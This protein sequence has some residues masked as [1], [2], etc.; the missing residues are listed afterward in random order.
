MPRLRHPQPAGAWILFAVLSCEALSRPPAGAAPLAP[1]TAWTARG[2]VVCGAAN[3]QDAPALAADGSGG[4]FL[5]WED[6][7]ARP[8]T[9]HVYAQHLLPDGTPA[10]GWAADGM[11]VCRARGIQ[12]APQVVGD[13][14]GGLFAVWQDDRA[15]GTL[16]VYGQ[17]LDAT[18]AVVSGWNTDGNALCTA[19]GVQRAPGLVSDGAGGAIV[20][21]EDYRRT[22]SL[23]VAQRVLG[24]GGFAPSW[25]DTGRLLAPASGGQVGPVM[26]TDGA[27]GAIVAWSDGRGGFATSPDIYAQRIQGDGTI[28]AG[29]PF[30]G[31]PVCAA[32]GVQQQPAIISDAAGGAFLAWTDSRNGPLNTFAQ[33]VS[34][35][36]TLPAGWVPDGISVCV[37]AFGELNP[38]LATDGAGRVIVT[39]SDLRGGPANADIYAQRLAPDGSA[40]WLA[41]GVPVSVA[42]GDQLTPQLV[43]DGAGGAIV[44]WQDGRFG[45]QT[46][47][48]AE[49]VTATGALSLG[50]PADGRALADTNLVLGPPQMVTDGAGGVILGWNGINLALASGTPDIFAA[51]LLG[52]GVVPVL[53]S[54]V[55]ADAWPD[56]VRLRWWT[57]RASTAVEIERRDPVSAW[58]SR[59]TPVTDGTGMLEW[60]DRDVV[61]GARYGW[62][63]R[64]DGG[65]AG[66]IWATVPLR[67]LAIAGIAPQPALSEA[68]VAVTLDGSAPARLSLFDLAGRRRWERVLDGSDP[69]PRFVLATAALEPGVYLLRLTQSGRTAHARLVVAR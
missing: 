10:P 48:Y 24:G 34:G 39:W 7:R 31:L 66:E 2:L 17:H 6:A 13:G 44:A 42:P 1:D 61:P 47:L 56:R 59:A 63:L 16:R 8:D 14:S 27:G 58:Q 69:A 28:P 51:R 5:V 57:P 40:E 38:Q 67:A 45:T 19:P 36:G 55:S 43:Y 32:G 52:S 18:G 62:R 23:V 9:T 54:A 65:P 3:A 64:V 68:R 37:T 22:Q 49:R 60:E 25:P 4:V 53:A 12:T 41:D 21:W 35:A 33:H 26:A 30:S 29:W 11:P 50:W 20:A 15:G 46:R